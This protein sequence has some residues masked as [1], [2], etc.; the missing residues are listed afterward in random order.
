MKFDVLEKDGFLEMV[1]LS[2]PKDDLKT[3]TALWLSRKKD[4][5]SIPGF[6]KGK[7]PI[8]LIQKRYQDTAL[9]ESYDELIKKNVT[10]VFKE[11][12]QSKSL[13]ENPV[14]KKKN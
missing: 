7:A 9:S 2:I 12:Y 1:R 14:I 4:L 10:K 8:A 3:E 5:I 13:F 11:H 6:R